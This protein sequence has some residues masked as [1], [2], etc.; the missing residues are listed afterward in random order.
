MGPC[1]LELINFLEPAVSCNRKSVQHAQG[2]DR[3]ANGFH[4]LD[5]GL[6][7]MKVSQQ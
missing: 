2:V 7:C 3:V 5:M 6:L 1:H 4:A